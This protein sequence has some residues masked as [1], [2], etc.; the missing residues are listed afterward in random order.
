VAQDIP[1]TQLR[2]ELTVPSKNSYVYKLGFRYAILWWKRSYDVEKH[3]AEHFGAPAKSF[4]YTTYRSNIMIKP[5]F[6]S[7][8]PKRWF[9]GSQRWND[10]MTTHPHWA[11]FKTEK[12]RTLALLT[13]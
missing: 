2:R 13:F 11:V 12:D 10:K 3:L 9:Y 4:H 7:I 8:T 6:Q 1:Y 5:S